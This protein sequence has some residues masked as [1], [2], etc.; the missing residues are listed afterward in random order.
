MDSSYLLIFFFSFHDPF[1]C[2]E[3]VGKEK[4]TKILNFEFSGFSL[5]RVCKAK[6]KKI[7]RKI[8]AVF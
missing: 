2:W 1:G 4:K 6:D 3:V 5:F 8:D 7:F